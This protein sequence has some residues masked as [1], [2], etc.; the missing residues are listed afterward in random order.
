MTGLG[1]WTHQLFLIYLIPLAWL[2]TSQYGWWTRRGFATPNGVVVTLAGTAALYFALGTIAFVTGGFSIEA[3]SLA[4]G[5]RAPQKMLRIGIGIA[6]LALVAHFFSTTSREDVRRLARRVWPVAAGFLVGYL[7]VLLYSIFV[8]PVRS[9]A[10]SA[11]LRDMI[12]AAPDIL[13]NIVPILA[14]FKIATT[15]RLPL[16]LIAIVP[17]AVTLFAY[18]WL[19][20]ARVTREFFPLFVL[21]V[22][23]LFLVSGAYLDTQSYRY[24]IPWYA[25]LSVAWATGSWMLA[26]K[27]QFGP[28]AARLKTILASAIVGLVIVVHAWQQ[29]EW[30]RKL[31]PD[32][33]SAMT[34]ECLK[35][36][37]IRGGFAEYWT[38]YKLT[39]LSR[40]EIT[41]A[42][43]DGVD[44]YPRYTELRAIAAREREGPADAGWS[45]LQPVAFSPH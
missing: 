35:R 11:N 33:V 10:R 1:L 25:G 14:G 41:I 44:R 45:I 27:V 8:E 22:P 36:N 13:G 39:F 3:G 17:G 15:E 29:V 19:T 12:Q 7:P 4:I 16:A 31:Q 9:P 28:N 2:H 38:A 5:V 37:G 23:L 18:V 43:E 21:F 40:E 6:A 34:L 30:Y 42:P 24:L 20:R 26:D 32:T